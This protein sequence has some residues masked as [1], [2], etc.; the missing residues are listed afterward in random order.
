MYKIRFR[1]GLRPRPH[2]RN[3][4]GSRPDPV[5]A[6]KGPISKGRGR[7]G[8]GKR[9]RKEGWKKGFWGPQSSPKID[10][11]ARDIHLY[12]NQHYVTYVPGAFFMHSAVPAARHVHSHGQESSTC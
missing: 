3:L 11:T 5:A 9:R 1:L 4:Q 6:F 10:A 2:L 12:F 8:E 7:A